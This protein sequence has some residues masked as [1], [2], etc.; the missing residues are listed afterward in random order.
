MLSAEHLAARARKLAE[1]QRHHFARRQPTRLLARLD[2]TRRILDEA[3]RELNE[4]DVAELNVGPA[5]DWLLDNFHVIQEHVRDVREA[6]PRGFYRELPELTG[7]P[8]AGYPR[9][10]EIATTLI[11]HTEGRVDV[12]NVDLFLGAFQEVTALT[13]GELWAMPAMLRLALIENVRRMALRTRDRLRELRLADS[14]ASRFQ[15]ASD[16]GQAALSGIMEQFIRRPPTLTPIFVSRF[17]RQVRLAGGE[18]AQLMSLE[19]WIADR[20]LT[21]DDAESRAT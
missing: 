7:G 14:W 17:L 18:L 10:Y 1:G 15:A 3:Y 16:E 4:P 8:L 13:L 21:A 19:H 9:A 20:G 12:D 6:L 11:S 2:E 5:A